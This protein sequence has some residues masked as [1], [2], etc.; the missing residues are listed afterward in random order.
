[1]AGS[2]AALDAAPARALALV[3]AVPVWA[4]LTAIVAVS[5]AVRF[6]FAQR[7]AAPW[8]VVDELIYSELA[9]SVADEGRL[10]IRGE[11]SYGY[12]VVYPL[13]VSPAYA[14]FDSLPAAYDALKAINSLLVSLAAVPAY[15][16]ARRVLPRGLAVFASLLA[17]SVPS[18][19][20]AGEVMTENAFYPLFLCVA[21]ALVLALER[22]TPLRQGVLLAVCVLAYLTRAQAL[23]FFAAAA[24][25]PFLVGNWRSFRVLYGAFAAGV[26]AVLGVQLVR[27]ESPLGV[28]G[29]YAVTGEHRYEPGEVARWLLYHLAELDVYLGIFPFAGV[30]RPARALGSAAERTAPPSSP[31]RP[32]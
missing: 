12:G 2:T 30:A 25:A 5:T 7:I 9:R 28:L 19:L 17:V 14:L 32:R 6:A 29:A 18:L 31:R 23:A 4:W 27:G 24:V 3:R 20:Y 16:L 21:L 1:M 22:P 10:L 8:I 13:L 26:V 15:F 11:P